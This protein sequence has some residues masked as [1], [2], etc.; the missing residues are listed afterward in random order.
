MIEFYKYH[1]TGNDFIMI[2]NRQGQFAGNKVDFAKKWCQRRFGIGSDGVIFI[3]NDPEV[4]FL[5]DFYNPDGSQ[6]FCGNGSRCSVAFARYLGIVDDKAKFKAIDGIHEAH[7]DNGLYCIHMG[8]VSGVERI[9]KD[10]F[11]QTGS[12]HYISYCDAEDNRD[13][14]EFGRS[15]RYN[16]R[17]KEEGT[18]VNLVEVT[19]KNKIDVRTYERGVENETFACGTGVTAA[20]LS[21]GHRE[22]MND[23]V[24]DVVVKGGK[25]KV[26]FQRKNDSFYEIWLIGPA[27]FVFKGVL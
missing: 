26:K 13:I 17:F 4:D 16:D 22:E 27:E 5:M 20:A 8:D 24:V 7:L 14:V 6:S 11:L 10:Y 12:P 3:E 18:N 9:N 1:G 15:I 21:Y 23:G 25:L 2:D 19:G